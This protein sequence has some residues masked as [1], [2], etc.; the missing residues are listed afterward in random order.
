M[1]L[2]SEPSMIDLKYPLLV[3]LK[4]LFTDGHYCKTTI[5]C[6]REGCSDYARENSQ[7]CSHKCGTWHMYRS[8]LSSK[9][10]EY[11]ESKKE[12]EDE[13]NR[14]RSEVIEKLRDDITKKDTVDYISEDDLQQLRDIW[15]EKS[16]W[17]SRKED[18]KKQFGQF[19]QAIKKAL[20]SD[21]EEH[22]TGKEKKSN[23][24]VDCFCCGH[25]FAAHAFL[26]HTESCFIKVCSIY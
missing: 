21:P 15:N 22:D 24:L 20:V 4:Y 16:V 26:A 6:I 23:D 9:Y 18:A 19:E 12:K 13:M 2:I 1:E 5:P 8:L 3:I 7:Y 11:L 10:E 14:T 17:E 25:T